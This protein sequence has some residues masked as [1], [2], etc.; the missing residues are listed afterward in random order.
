MRS[1]MV[2]E[3]IGGTARGCVGDMVRGYVGG[4]ARGCV[5][6]VVRGCV[7]ALGK[8]GVGIL[9]CGLKLALNVDEGLDDFRNVF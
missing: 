7:L 1:G 3:C 9:G 5:G 8:R 6:G 4:T 2:R